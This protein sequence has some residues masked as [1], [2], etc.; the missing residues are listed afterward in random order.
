MLTILRLGA[1]A[2]AL[3]ASAAPALAGKRV[4]LVIGN[5]AYE[6][7]PALLK[8][9][10]DARAM[11]G[12]LETL[13]FG[14][15]TA[16]NLTRRGMSEALLAFERRIEPG[17]TAFFFFAGHGFEIRG[18]NYLLPTDVPVPA[19]GGEELIR[20]AAFAV[21]RVVERLQARGVRTAIL[22]LDACRDNPFERT[23]T[24]SVVGAGG[25]APMA[26]LPEGVFL[27]Y[28]AGFKQTA[29]DRLSNNDPNPNSVFTRRFVAEI[30][31]PG[32]TLVQVAK[33][34]QVGVKRLAATARHEQTPAYYDQVVGDVVLR[35]SA[36]GP[37]P[38]APPLQGAPQ[39]AMKPPASPPA[40]A[41]SVPDPVNAPYADIQRHN[42]GWTVTLSF[43]DP[44]TAISWRLGETGAFRE[45][46]FLD[47][48]EPR[49]RRRMPNPSIQLPPDA[50]EGTLQVRAIDARGE[51]IGPFPVRFD[52]GAALEKGQRTILEMTSGSW[53]AFREFN[54]LLLYTTH[55]MAY[56]CAIREARIGIDS[57]VPDRKVAMP[58]CDPREPSSIPSTAQPYLKLPPAT[59]SV[60][61]ELTYR[62]GS[63]SEVK[64]FRR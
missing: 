21:D 12:A 41:P 32:L 64:T 14:V 3:L 18:I 39:V 55:L 37:P 17:D 29:L 30:A 52:P 31:T 7:V 47:A 13:G 35:A 48:L 33:R 24:R 51:P 43:A 54:G 40:P 5:D 38:E 34:T 60:S 63:V 53:V 11:T 27:I 42:G 4:A 6:T 58:P 22:V 59:R 8:A 16:E 2:L 1:L 50:E 62:D 61:V 23:G 49:T 10:S 46:G 36:G 20:D 57:A 15:T 25:L 45:T 56:R 19:P 9:A 28:S 26:S 44:V